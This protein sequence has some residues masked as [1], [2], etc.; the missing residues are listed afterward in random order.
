LGSVVEVVT[1][2]TLSVSLQHHI[3]LTDYHPNSVFADT[4][5]RRA[6]TIGF[7]GYLSFGV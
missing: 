6:P 5:W 2:R 3:L 4:T 7:S 1:I